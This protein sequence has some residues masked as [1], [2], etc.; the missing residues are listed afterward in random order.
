MSA[1]RVGRRAGRGETGGLCAR[2]PAVVQDRLQPVDADQRPC[3]GQ[4]QRLAI[5]RALLRAPGV[6]LFDDAFSALDLATEARLRV[7]LRPRIRDAAA[8]VQR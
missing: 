1:L 5:A 8:P 7:A 3:R 4:R 6:Y 2:R